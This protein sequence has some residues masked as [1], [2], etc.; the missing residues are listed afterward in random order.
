[1]RSIDWVSGGPGAISKRRQR[2]SGALG[3]SAPQCGACNVDNARPK[4]GHGR[5]GSPWIMAQS[6][7]IS[8]SSSIPAQ[9][10][11]RSR[12]NGERPNRRT[13]WARAG[14]R[15]AKR[16]RPGNHGSRRG[17]AAQPLLQRAEACRQMR[18]VG[19][20]RSDSG[21]P[22]RPSERDPRS[23][24]IAGGVAV[25]RAFGIVHDHLCTK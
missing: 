2:R 4:L 21:A 10:S 23:D 22:R 9:S 16:R 15:S 14:G 24:R 18:P 5:P 8:A 1:M 3:A 13:T 6:A 19:G 25:E 11:R 17:L 7:A 12:S 20:S